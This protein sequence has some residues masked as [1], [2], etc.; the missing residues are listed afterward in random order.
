VIYNRDEKVPEIDFE[1]SKKVLINRKMYNN[2]LGPVVGQENLLEPREDLRSSIP[3]PLYD[4][5][6]L[7]SLSHTLKI[8][9]NLKKI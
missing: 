5:A 4:D 2:F 6:I 1:L 7:E 9:K 8:F 3:K